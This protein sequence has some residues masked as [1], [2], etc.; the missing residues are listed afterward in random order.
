MKLRLKYAAGVFMHR[1]GAHDGHN[2]AD[3]DWQHKG[4]GFAVSLP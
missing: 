4:K 1:V 2:E 3:G